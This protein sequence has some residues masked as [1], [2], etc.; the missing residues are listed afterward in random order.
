MAVLFDILTTENAQF[1]FDRAAGVAQYIQHSDAIPKSFPYSVPCSL[2]I[3]DPQ[4]RNATW[5]RLTGVF[6][7]R[8]HLLPVPRPH[9]REKVHNVPTNTE[10]EDTYSGSYTELEILLYTHDV[11]KTMSEQASRLRDALATSVAHVDGVQLLAISVP[12]ASWLSVPHQLASSETVIAAITGLGISWIMVGFLTA[13][14]CVI[15]AQRVRCTG[16][17]T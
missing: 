3:Q 5:P 11:S 2:W 4:N 8:K 12:T 6:D 17:P 1:T 14:C 16:A 9:Y 15:F 7:I 10:L 13:M